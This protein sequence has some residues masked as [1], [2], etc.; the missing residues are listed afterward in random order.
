MSSDLICAIYD[1]THTQTHKIYF[2]RKCSYA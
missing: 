1:H 2:K